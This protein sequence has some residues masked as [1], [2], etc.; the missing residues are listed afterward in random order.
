MNRYSKWQ[1]VEYDFIEAK[2]PVKFIYRV[3]TNDMYIVQFSK[4][5]VTGFEKEWDHLWIRSKHP[6]GKDIPWAE[7]QRIKEDFFP[8]RFGYE[9]FPPESDLVDQ[10]NMYHIYIAPENV[11]P[12]YGL[13]KVENEIPR[14][15]IPDS[16]GCKVF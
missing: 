1:E 10:A 8:G 11:R 7:K 14:N 5:L 12:A 15:K 3:V 6:I 9:M 16:F 4:L 2:N 13:H